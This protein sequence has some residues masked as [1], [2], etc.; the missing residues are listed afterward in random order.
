MTM[1][2][3][4]PTRRRPS[5][6]R[7]RRFRPPEREGGKWLLVGGGV[8]GLGLLAL[9]VVLLL[10]GRAP[11]DL[12]P[13]PEPTPPVEATVIPEATSSPTPLPPTPTPLPT[14]TPQPRPC[15]TLAQ[16]WVR[17]QPDEDSIGRALL[18]PGETVQ[19]LDIV[20]GADGRWYA[21]AGYS[22]PAY[23]RI[24]NVQCGP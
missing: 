5:S 19:V 18:D 20:E 8:V 14:A 22:G 4:R 11:S 23:V 24:E 9:L 17:S 21:L 6:V 2:D 12:A 7:E 13:T 3:R 16:T 1:R 10:R 15:R